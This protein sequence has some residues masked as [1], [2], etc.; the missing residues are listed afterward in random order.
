[1]KSLVSRFVNVLYFYKVLFKSK[2]E[3]SYRI[4]P[5]GVLKRDV[6]KILN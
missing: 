3:K 4:F 1:M 2:E 6:F 5:S